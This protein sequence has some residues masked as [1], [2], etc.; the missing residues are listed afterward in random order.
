MKLTIYMSIVLV[1]AATL[2]TGGGDS[3]AEEK[4]A[5]NVAADDWKT[6][7]NLSG[8]FSVEAK[9][10]A[11]RDG[12][13]ILVLKNQIEVSVPLEQLDRTSLLQIVRYLQDPQKANGKAPKPVRLPMGLLDK[14]LEAADKIN[15]LPAHNHERYSELARPVFEHLGQ[16]RLTALP[17]GD[18]PRDRL[19]RPRTIKIWYLFTSGR[20]AT[21]KVH[22]G[23]PVILRYRGDQC[24]DKTNLFGNLNFTVSEQVDG[25]WT[26]QKT[27]DGPKRTCADRWLVYT[28]KSD[29]IRIDGQRPCGFYIA[30][31]DLALATDQP[32]DGPA[33][34]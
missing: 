5:D 4:S 31:F 9:L 6:W 29:K 14:A 10:T 7:K 16:A 34:Q 11:V 32:P 19:G 25:K 30:V 15:Q 1:A 3:D 18:D 33:K 20:K 27:V 23:T 21:F 12:K 26:T 2:L 8:E 17:P 24:P 28:P 22:P 13:A